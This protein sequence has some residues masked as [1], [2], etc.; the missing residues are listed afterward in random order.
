MARYLALAKTLLFL[1]RVSV[2][3]ASAVSIGS[4]TTDSV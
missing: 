4:G 1:G 3:T 2:N